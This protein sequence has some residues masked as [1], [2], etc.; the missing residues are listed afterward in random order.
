[1]STPTLDARGLPTGT[2]LRPDEVSPREARALAASGR[3][4]VVDV[5][6]Q[7]EW[8]LVHVPGSVHI[9]LPEI[10][11]RHDEIEPAPG[12]Q[13]AVLCHHGVRSLKATHT[14]RA[15]RPDLAD[16]RSIAGGIELW[17]LAADAGVPRYERGP[18]VLRLMP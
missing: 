18:G 7:E 15:L 11:K 13:V 10:E 8:D 14:L 6:T 1:M 5:R 9:P 2:T 3:A 17:S 12:R 4:L 16:C